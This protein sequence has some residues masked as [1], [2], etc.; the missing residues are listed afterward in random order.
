MALQ[1]WLKRAQSKIRE[2]REFEGI[3]AAN[4]CDRDVT[5]D[6]DEFRITFA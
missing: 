1:A 5:R 3:Y 2:P 6:R 4:F